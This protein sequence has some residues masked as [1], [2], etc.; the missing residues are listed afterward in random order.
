MKIVLVT[1]INRQ[2]DWRFM[3]MEGDVYEVD[4]PKD[5]D[6]SLCAIGNKTPTEKIQFV[7][8]FKQLREIISQ[9]TLE[10]SKGRRPN[11]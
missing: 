9:M 1:N 10:K 4:N 8:T 11:T 3:D 7:I 6:C 5:R 2:G